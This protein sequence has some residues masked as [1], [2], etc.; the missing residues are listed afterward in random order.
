ML[1]SARALLELHSAAGSLAQLGG[2]LLAA[3][4]MP[5]ILPAL[6][7]RPRLA[8]RPVKC[9]LAVCKRAIGMQSAAPCLVDEA[10]A[11]WRACRAQ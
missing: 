11:L 3:S 7:H 2:E 5:A 1:Y 9:G 6:P 10:L 8:A 4:T